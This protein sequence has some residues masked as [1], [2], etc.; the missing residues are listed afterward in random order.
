MKKHNVAI[1]EK[2]PVADFYVYHHTRETSVRA[3]KSESARRRR[4][5]LRQCLERKDIRGVYY[6]EKERLLSIPIIQKLIRLMQ[7]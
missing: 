7:N 1:I 3:V 6:I 5:L 2:L 4:K